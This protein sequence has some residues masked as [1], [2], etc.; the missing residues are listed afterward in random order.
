LDRTTRKTIK[1]APACTATGIKVERKADAEEPEV[2]V[3]AV[4]EELELCGG[5]E[6]QRQA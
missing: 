2:V 1:N 3:E 6:G 5:L 4:E